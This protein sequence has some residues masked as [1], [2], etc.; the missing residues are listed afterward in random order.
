MEHPWEDCFFHSYNPLHVAQFN[1][2]SDEVIVPIISHRLSEET[3]QVRCDTSSFVHEP[4]SRALVHLRKNC[5]PIWISFANTVTKLSL[6]W[7]SALLNKQPPPFRSQVPQA[8][9]FH[10]VQFCRP[11]CHPRLQPDPQLCP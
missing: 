2:V 9:E 7:V 8:T 11:L 4:A 3:D 1:Y 5:A 10:Q 6:L